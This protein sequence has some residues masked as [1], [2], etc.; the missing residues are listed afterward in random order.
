MAGSW[1]TTH[2]YYSGDATNETVHGTIADEG[3]SGQEG[4][5]SLFGEGGNDRIDGGVGSDTLDGG[6]GNDDLTDVGSIPSGFTGIIGRDTLRGGDGDDVLSFNSP[7][8]GD[9]AFGDAGTDTIDLDFRSATATQRVTFRLA[10]NTVVK[11]NDANTVAVSS[12]ERV[13]FLGGYG[14]DFVTGGALDDRLVGGLGGYGF[15]HDGNDALRGMGGNDWIEGGTGIQQIDG[16]EDTDTASFDLSGAGVALRIVSG[17]SINLGA[18]GSVR[19]VENLYDVKT[20]TGNDIFDID[21]AS[22]ISI[23]SGDGADRITV[24]DGGG[25]IYAGQGSDVVRMGA[26]GDYVDPGYGADVVYLGAGNDVSQNA[27]RNSTEA[28]RIYGEGG[29]DTIYASAGADRINGGA[30]N[31]T[32]YAGGGDDTVLGGDG[33][34]RIEGEGGADTIDGGAGN[35]TISDGYY[36]ADTLN[37]GEGND[38]ITGGIGLDTLNGGLGDDVLSVHF[39]LGG[40][41]FDAQ[42]DQ[43]N[44]GGGIDTLRA[45]AGVGVVTVALG[46]TTNL[47][48]NGQTVAAAT[49]VERLTSRPLAPAVTRSRAVASRIESS[50]GRA[51]TRSTRSA[52]TI[53]FSVTTMTAAATTR[54][55]QAPATTP[56]PFISAAATTWTW[57]PQ[58]RADAF[59]RLYRSDGAIEVRRRRRDRHPDGLY[60]VRLRRR[61]LRWRHLTFRGHR[62]R[63]CVR[64]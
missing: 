29:N 62:Y 57:K 48:Y 50:P 51:T 46:A 13:V 14:D 8:T 12:I 38:R 47:L 34:D 35:D 44:G 39:E 41:A 16:G 54:S 9:K 45:A 40:G 63:Q 17:A 59:K 60:A 55:W 64:V 23:T 53:T 18:W 4:D 1:N 36:E 21:Q 42:V 5:D 24:G 28:D 37:G 20:S 11:L 31:D 52:A 10:P 33:N 26:A 6:I 19:N 49:F 3:L 22:R 15:G 7:D 27:D 2:T 32:I 61:V 58:R 30:D 25:S 43:L 56:P